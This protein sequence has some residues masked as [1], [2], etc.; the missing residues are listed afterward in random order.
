VAD[1][2]LPVFP[3]RANW[4]EAML[5]RL[6][7]LTDVRGGREGAEQRASL[8][9]TPRRTY[10]IDFL[11]SGAERTFYDLFI[12]RFSGDEFM[13]PL[14]WDVAR[15]QTPLV[16]TVTDRI[17]FNTTYTDFTV[18]GLALISGRTALEFEV[19]RDSGMGRRVE[20]HALAALRPRR[21][22]R[23][24]APLGSGRIGHGC[25]PQ[26]WGERMDPGC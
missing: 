15:S 23:G 3:F 1:I 6:S 14:Y 21:H 18:D 25:L 22:L 10:E 2:D 7:F 17:E 11:L 13:A 16:A 8:R 20:G 19:A 4:R 12:D 5:E 24:P 9:Q 26:H